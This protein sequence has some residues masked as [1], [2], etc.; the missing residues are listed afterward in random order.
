MKIIYLNGSPRL[1]LS[2]S[3][4]FLNDIKDKQN[5]IYY[6]YKDK[7]DEIISGI[8][9][10]DTIVLAFPLYVDSPTS[11][12]LRF[13]EYIKDNNID[14]SG[15][16]LYAIINCGFLEAKQNDVARDIVKLFCTNNNIN[17]MGCIRIGAG[18]II[19]KKKVSLLY[20]LVSI[21]YYFKINKFKRAILNSN[22]ADIATTI[23]PVPKWL[24]VLIANLSFNS[25]RKKYNYYEKIRD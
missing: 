17:Y 9:K 23:H 14:I 11:G 19:G 21:S 2:N 22:C 25:E 20:K 8:K 3:T 15:K 13:F 24:Y 10:C 18:V 16:N 7:F 6:L 1:K 12:T 5:K 4:S